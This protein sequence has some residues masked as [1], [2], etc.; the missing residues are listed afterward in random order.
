M[1]DIKRTSDNTRENSVEEPKSPD[2]WRRMC[3]LADQTRQ[4]T[5]KQIVLSDR[6]TPEK[7]GLY[8]GMKKSGAGASS[9]SAVTSEV[10][11]PKLRSMDK[12]LT[13]EIMPKIED[14]RK[15]DSSLKKEIAKVEES[16]KRSCID[17]DEFDALNDRLCQLRV[18]LKT[19]SWEHKEIER[20][21]RSCLGGEKFNRGEIEY[22]E[23][24]WYRTNSNL[25]D[26]N[27]S[28][29]AF[30]IGYMLDEIKLVRKEKK[31]EEERIRAYESEKA[32]R[33][34]RIRNSEIAEEWWRD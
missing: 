28:L 24:H 32:E 14:N 26:F 22:M 21:Q 23:R 11:Y 30:S 7:P 20:Q 29:K 25:R 31:E 18:E 8:G 15:R 12:Y 2:T 13:R 6:A 17:D 9:S 1:Q 5:E 10:V 27:K 34:E 19:N 3:K 4:Q 33:E 16:L